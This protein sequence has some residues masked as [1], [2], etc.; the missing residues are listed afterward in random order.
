ML[1]LVFTLE[2][3]SFQMMVK[4]ISKMMREYSLSLEEQESKQYP[5]S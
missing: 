5:A 4:T 3:E 2:T 1:I